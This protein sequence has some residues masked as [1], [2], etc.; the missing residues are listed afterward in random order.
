MALGRQNI[1][2]LC[3]VQRGVKSALRL[4]SVGEHAGISSAIALRALVFHAALVA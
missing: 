1:S 4:Q 2:G 3:T